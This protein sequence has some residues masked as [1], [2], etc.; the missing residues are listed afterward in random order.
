MLREHTTLHAL[1]VWRT[2]ADAFEGE[3]LIRQQ[4]A[5][6]GIVPL[7]RAIRSLEAAGFVLHNA[8]FESVLAEGLIAC[9][10]HDEADAIVSN[11][12]ARCQHSG[13]AWCVPEL[14]RVLALSLAAHKRTEEA[15]GLV[16]DGLEIAR[17]QGALAWELK[18][19]LTLVAIDDRDSA[20][21]RLREILNRTTE[22]FGTQN[23]REAVAMLG[24]CSQTIK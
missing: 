22:G 14:M 4:N 20:M 21:D 13:A 5:L 11:A 17:S 2:Y 19:A 12:L 7:R 16:V 24:Q 15:I 9:G 10:R 1:D 3:I 8:A 18:L 23:Y 6:E